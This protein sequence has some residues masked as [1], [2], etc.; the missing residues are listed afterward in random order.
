MERLLSRW[1]V[2][3]FIFVLGIIIVGALIE[4]AFNIESAATKLFIAVGGIGAVALFFK[5]KG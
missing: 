1:I 5:L 4:D 2:A 3:P